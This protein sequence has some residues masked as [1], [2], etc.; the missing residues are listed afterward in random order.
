[1]VEVLMRAPGGGDVHLMLVGFAEP[2]VRPNP[3]RAANTIGMWRA[4][5]LLPDLDRAAAALRAAGVALLSDPQSMSMG[6]G[7]PELRFVCFRGPDQE[8]IELIEQPP[9]TAG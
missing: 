6:P 2:S 8:V 3:P 7:L 1:M 9:T 4:A 5:L